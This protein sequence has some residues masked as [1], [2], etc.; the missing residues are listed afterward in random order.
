MQLAA[1]VDH[2]FHLSIRATKTMTKHH[3]ARLSELTTGTASATT[4][5]AVVQVEV[6]V[7]ARM[8]RSRGMTCLDPFDAHYG[9][10]E[11]CQE[12]PLTSFEDNEA[13]IQAGLCCSC[14]VEK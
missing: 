10:F 9:H 13:Y 1:Q 12:Q 7:V 6:P 8:V 3:M 2:I 11:I 14:S 4:A 5:T